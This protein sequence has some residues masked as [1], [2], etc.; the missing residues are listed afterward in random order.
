MKTIL[1]IIT[2]LFVTKWN[3][4]LSQ[5]NAGIA[6]PDSL[7]T[8][9]DFWLGDWVVRNAKGDTLGYNYIHRLDDGCGLHEHWTSAKGFKGTSISFYNVNTNQWHQSWI[10]G[11]GVS[12]LMDGKLE[13]GT[14]VMW[15]KKVEGGA[16]YSQ[17]KTSW[18]P[19][20]DGRVKHIWENTVDGGKTWSVVFE[21]YYSPRSEG[22]N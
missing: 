6:C 4:L 13:N 14:M 10:D 5:T 21:G 16:G 11:Q 7:Y 3:N 18:T 9:F 19:L 15:T 8:Q 1:I 22:G 2:M 12:I 20:N 17:N